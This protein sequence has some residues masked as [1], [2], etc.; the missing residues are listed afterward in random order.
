VTPPGVSS[1]SISK[2]SQYAGRAFDI[3]FGKCKEGRTGAFA[4]RRPHP[5]LRVHFQN[6]FLPALRSRH[7]AKLRHLCYFPLVAA[8]VTLTINVA[9]CKYTL[10]RIYN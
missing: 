8:G 6:H 4:L 3:F 5:P 1:G 9:T 2:W 7:Y 10:K